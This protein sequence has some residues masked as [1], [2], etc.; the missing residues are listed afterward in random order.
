MEAGGLYGGDTG[1][2]VLQLAG[3]LLKQILGDREQQEL[4]LKLKSVL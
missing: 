4:K 3:V 2:L 1:L